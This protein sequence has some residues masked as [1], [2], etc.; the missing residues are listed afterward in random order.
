MQRTGILIRREKLGQ[1]IRRRQP[2]FFQL[3]LLAQRA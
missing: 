1:E 2:E 3:E